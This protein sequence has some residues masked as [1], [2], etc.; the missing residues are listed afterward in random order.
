MKIVRP[1]LI[2]NGCRSRLDHYTKISDSSNYVRA[3]YNQ[4]RAKRS[5]WILM[6]RKY[7]TCVSSRY[8][9]GFD[10]NRTAPGHNVRLTVS[11]GWPTCRRSSV[12]HMTRILD[13][14]GIP[15]NPWWKCHVVTRPDNDSV[16]D[17]AQIDAPLCI[18]LTIAVSW[19]ALIDQSVVDVQRCGI[20]DCS[21]C[22]KND[23]YRI[24]QN[25]IH[26]LYRS[27]S[28]KIIFW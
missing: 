27:V 16:L 6:G 17:T 2:T 19:T 14:E 28:V 9:E 22:I 5:R 18:V 25:Y 20:V 4:V 23:I 12:N 24:I 3:S 26:F 21:Y 7:V 11:H 1:L 8:R 10:A 13:G 15:V